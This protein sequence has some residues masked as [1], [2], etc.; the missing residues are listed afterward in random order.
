MP[1]LDTPGVQVSAEDD[2]K[3]NRCVLNPKR[4]STQS[5]QLS[6]VACR[7]RGWGS[8]LGRESKAS[9]RLASGNQDQI[10]ASLINQE[11]F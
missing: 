5:G 10:L 8:S 7:Q 1:S 2:W 3:S 11:I 9:A 4:L 6:E